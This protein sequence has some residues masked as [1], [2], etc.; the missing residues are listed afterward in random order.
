MSERVPKSIAIIMDGNRR[1]ARER[2]LPT[3]EGHRAGYEKLK[4][5]LIWSREVGIDFLT[6]YAFSTENWKRAPEEVEGLMDIF[7]IL[8]QELE[9][10]APERLRLRFIGDK[11]VFPEDIRSAMYRI[12]E[13]TADSGP[14]TLAVAVSYGGR[15]EIMRAACMCK[16][17]GD[18]L[19]E[20]AFAASLST[21]G[22][23]DPDLVIRTGGEQRLSNFLLWQSAYS[24]LFFL[25]T[26]WPAFSRD[27]FDR[28]LAD[29]ALRER[30]FGA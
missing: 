10:S 6:V 14:H 8:A 28:V 21:A 29:F 24:E 23:P 18:A 9:S 12:E 3:L 27:E 26:H 22:I 20:D 4:E 1:Y 16:D 19:S 15:Q 25:D 2:G 5:V 30:R 11:D 13:R 7:R 17:Q